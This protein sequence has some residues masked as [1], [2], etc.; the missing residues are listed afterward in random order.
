ME[1]VVAVLRGYESLAAN[2]WRVGVVESKRQA[3]TP[4]TMTFKKI[5]P[6]LLAFF[7]KNKRKQS[8]VPSWVRVAP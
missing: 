4:R 6:R 1:P 8:L 5:H 3:K 2:I 7:G